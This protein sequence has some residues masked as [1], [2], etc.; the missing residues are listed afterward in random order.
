MKDNRITELENELIESKNK[1]LSV[2][3]SLENTNKVRQSFEILEKVQHKQVISHCPLHL[4]SLQSLQDELQ[5]AKNQFQEAQLLH[6]TA[7]QDLESKLG[8]LMV[9][10]KNSREKLD[11]SQVYCSDTLTI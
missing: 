1:A 4:E 7:K 3:E 10:L 8:N 6:Q 5:T 9:S 2:Q 11:D